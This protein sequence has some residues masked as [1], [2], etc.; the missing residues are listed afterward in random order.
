MLVTNTLAL[1]GGL[2]F[3]ARR[4]FLAT[5][6]VA[7]D[8]ADRSTAEHVTLDCSRVEALDEGTLGMLVTVARA[9][10]RR[11]ARVTL[12]RVSTNVLAQLDTAGASHFFD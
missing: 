4:E 3:D 5:A 10:Q 9:A 12:S 2:N 1:V 7:I 11:G 8:Q 6:T